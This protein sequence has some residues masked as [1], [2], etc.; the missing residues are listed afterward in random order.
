MADAVEALLA[1]AEILDER[2]EALDDDR[3]EEELREAAEDH[4]V[5]AW[6]N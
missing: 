2:L 4:Y 1:T 6:P 3:L 5:S